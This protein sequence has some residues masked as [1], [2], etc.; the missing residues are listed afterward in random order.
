MRYVELTKAKVSHAVLANFK[1][2]HPDFDDFLTNEAATCSS[3]GKGVTYILADDDEIEKGI[4]TIFAFAT[5]KASALQYM[6]GD[7]KLLSVPCAEIK[8]FAISKYFQKT[9]TGKL[10]LGKNYST[11]FFEI[12]LMDLY[13]MSTSIIGFTGIFLRA[14]EQGEH[15]YRRKNFVDATNFIIPYDE[16][17]KSGKC[18]PMYL[19]ISENIYEIFGVD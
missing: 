18:I 15:L 2:G 3:E 9:Q 19:S 1:C 7:S 10:G 5:I 17:D 14:N 11:I 16:D 4:T 8:Y 6:T 12:L 13:E